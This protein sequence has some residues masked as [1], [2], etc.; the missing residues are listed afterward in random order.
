MTFFLKRLRNRT[1]AEDLTQ[2][3]VLQDIA[4]PGH[5]LH[6]AMQSG[7]KCRQGCLAPC[8]FGEVPQAGI[9]GK[10]PAIFCGQG[11]PPEPYALGG[12][13]GVG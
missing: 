1:E 3:M 5:A 6:D 12:P 10:W 9:S 7:H 4:R 11:N 2:E 8:R 13:V